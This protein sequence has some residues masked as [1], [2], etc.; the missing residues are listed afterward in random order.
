MSEPLLYTLRARAFNRRKRDWLRMAI[1]LWIM[2]GLL[3]CAQRNESQEDEDGVGY[4]LLGRVIAVDA[5]R[6]EAK[7]EHEEIPGFMPEMTMDFRVGAGDAQILKPGMQIKARMTRD[8]DGGFRLV[9]VWEVDAVAVQKMKAINKRYA[10]EARD[11]GAGRYFGEGDRLPDF[12]LLDQFGESVTPARFAGKPFV[13]NFIF[14]RC[15][16]P[17]MCP[18][19][20]SKMAQLQM[21]AKERELK[22]LQFVSISLDPE[23]DTPGV[24][25]EFADRYAIDGSNFFFVTGAKEHVALLISSLG[26][27]KLGSGAGLNHSLATVLVDR[28]R[29]IVLRSEKSDWDVLAYLEK[30]SG[31]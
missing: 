11:L 25:R 2:A 14:T 22:D 26:V 15:T 10:Q 16:D 3:G 24:L 1:G 12:A 20:T 8:E 17:K 6:R 5:E 23:F 31:L 28:D 19:S 21:L 9:N 13:L 4:P 30:A 7:V 27:T 29:N 18:L